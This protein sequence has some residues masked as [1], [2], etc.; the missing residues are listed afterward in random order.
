[1]GK[2]SEALSYLDRAVSLDPNYVEAHY[3]RANT[4][5]ELGLFDEARKAYAQ[6]LR[7]NPNYVEALNN[8]GV[9]SESKPTS[10]RYNFFPSSPSQ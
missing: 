5:K 3:N 10:R 7:L 2:I 4:L 8:C 9:L 1:M 6:A